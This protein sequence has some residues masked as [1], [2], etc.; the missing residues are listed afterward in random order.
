MSEGQQKTLFIISPIGE[1]D[2][3]IRKHFDVVQRNLIGEIC[4]PMDYDCIRADQVERPGTITSQIV[5]LI[6]E[7]DLVIADLTGLNPNVFYELAIRHA[8]DK[9]AILIAK[10]GTKL[11]FDIRPER[12][13]FYTLNYVDLREAQKQLR[14]FVEAVESGKYK[15]ES[16]IKSKI[17]IETT[18]EVSDT[19][20]KETIFSMIDELRLDL[21]NAGLDLDGEIKGVHYLVPEEHGFVLMSTGWKRVPIEISYYPPKVVMPQSHIALPDYNGTI[22]MNIPS[23]KENGLHR[24]IIEQGEESIEI[25]IDLDDDA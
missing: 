8:I 20:F 12:V 22:Q 2:S 13:I 10:K 19:E 11:P 6:I 3:D 5:D 25:H 23:N 1:E 16:P 18:E 24:V 4:Q 14:S 7:A 9:P 17:K 21:Q 15:I